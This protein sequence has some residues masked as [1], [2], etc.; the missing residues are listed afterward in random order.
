MCHLS[1]FTSI[2][3]LAPLRSERRAVGSLHPVQSLP[4]PMS[5]SWA[6]E[7]SHAALTGDPETVVVLRLLAETIGMS[8]FDLEDRMK[9]LHHA[10]AAA[11]ANFVTAS[12]VLAT[13]LGTRAGV[14][15][16]TYRA[17]TDTTVVHAWRLGAVESLTGPIARGDVGTVAGQLEAIEVDAPE[18]AAA[19]AAMVR[20]TAALTP[21]ADL[22]D[23]LV[24]ERS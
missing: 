16:D 21:Y 18:L 6:L 13:R 14:P 12:L 15:P 7:G 17:L 20:A 5:G 3:V 19:Y 8:A 9:P 23:S 10:A 2:E 4:D 22:F 24:R 1:G 11:A